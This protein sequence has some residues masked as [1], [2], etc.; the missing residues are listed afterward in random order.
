MN[1]NVNLPTWGWQYCCQSGW[2]FQVGK[3]HFEEQIVEARWGIVRHKR[4]RLKGQFCLHV[5]KSKW[6]I[7]SHGKPFA[8]YRMDPETI[9]MKLS[10][11][12]GIFLKNLTFH[13]DGW[14]LQ[15]KLDA[16]IIIDNTPYAGAEAN[17][18]AN[19]LVR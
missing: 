6:R 5:L 16:D 3:P 15:A 13:P 8:N 1:K 9:A 12:E 4:A 10:Q 18:I 19:W 7:I 14:V 2:S 17:F 11:L